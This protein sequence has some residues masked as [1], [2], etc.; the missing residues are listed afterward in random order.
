MA[1]IEKL[2][3]NLGRVYGKTSS[4]FLDALLGTVAEQLRVL[5]KDI[6]H[7]TAQLTIPTASEDWLEY[8]GTVFG[9]TRSSLH[10]ADT[11]YSARIIEETVR[12]RPQPDALVDIV[13]KTLGV[14]MVVRDLW[15]QVMMTN[16]FV[17]PAGRPPQVLNGH[18]AEGWIPGD[19]ED[20]AVRLG[21]APPYV[22]GAVG[23][24]MDLQAGESFAYTLE[25]VQTLL[26]HILFLNE[27][28]PGATHVLNGQLT[29]PDLGGASD[30]ATYTFQVQPD[31]LPSTIEDVLK[32]IKK[33]R[34]AGTEA[35]FMG[36][37]VP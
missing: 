18:V 8:W 5:G 14:T 23:V 26:P 29:S 33:H 22:E 4:P 2:K 36:F 12:Q 1:T 20:L 19:V 32:V 21:I 15:P 17:V 37:V 25:N 16:Q 34:A 13:E 7:A 27:L 3:G 24:W 28:T 35:I 9:P 10:E 31:V 6:E 30:T 11:A